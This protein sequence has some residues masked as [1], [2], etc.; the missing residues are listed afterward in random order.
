[1]LYV[2]VDVSCH[3][4]SCQLD[5]RRLHVGFSLSYSLRVLYSISMYNAKL[6]GICSVEKTYPHWEFNPP[7]MQPVASHF[8]D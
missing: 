1:V 7:T 3:K 5:L 4:L 8:I 6:V 2:L